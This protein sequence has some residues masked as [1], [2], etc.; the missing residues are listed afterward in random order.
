MRDFIIT[1]GGGAL[2]G[3]T[4]ERVVTVLVLVFCAGLVFYPLFFLGT[5]SLNAGDPRQIP[6]D[7]FGIEAF[8]QVFAT[9]LGVVWNTVRIALMAA[10]VALPLGFIMAWIIYRTRLPGRAFFAQAFVLPYYVTPLVGAL[11]WMTLAAPQGGFINQAWRAL[12]GEGH[13]VNINSAVGIAFVM[14]LFE[15]AVAFVMI[16]AAMKSMDP[17]LEE[18]SQV[19]GAGKFRTMRKVTLPLLKP[20]VFGAAVFV[21]A[22]MLGAFA[23]PLVLG[24]S[25]GLFTITTSIYELINSFPPNYPLAA[26]LGISLFGI[27]FVM[28]WAYQRVLRRGSSFVTVS[29]KAFRPRP[30]SVGKLTLPFFLLCAGYFG[31]AVILPLGALLMSSFQQFATADVLN[32]RWTLQNYELAIGLGPVRQALGNSIWLG[33]ATASVGVPLMGFLA[34]LIYKSPLPQRVG[35]AMEYVVMFPLAVPRLVFGLAL[36]WAWL[37][38]P[39]PIYGTLWLLWLAYLTVFLPLGIRTIGGVVLQVDKSLEECA[40]VCGA[41][42]LYQL[43]TVTMPLLRPGLIAAW[44][45]LFIASMRELGA[46]IMLQ[47]PQSKVIGPAIVE[48]YASSGSTLTAAMALLQMAAIAIAL[49]IMFLATRGREKDAVGI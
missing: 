30:V 24:S 26:A 34:W 29:G 9:N 2:R 42:R 14:A 25:E 3:F 22:E 28:M 8:R 11:A 46:S 40:R 35:K 44:L 21:F 45:L 10:G 15:G 18:S 47:G 41:G 48:S 31:V 5:A 33:F 39:I 43:R 16:S 4:A 37:L 27:M 19:F 23:A 32:A 20:A 1:R 12:G 6:P 7:Q 38:I 36:L 49:V 17:A 13:L